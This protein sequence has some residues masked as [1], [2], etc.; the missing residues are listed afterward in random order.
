MIFRESILHIK[1]LILLTANLV[2]YAICC[3]SW[4]QNISFL[5]N[6]SAV[7]R[8]SVCPNSIFLIRRVYSNVLFARLV[9]VT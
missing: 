3:A 4:A 9:S 5:N 6:F 8:L 2:I 7:T 1:G